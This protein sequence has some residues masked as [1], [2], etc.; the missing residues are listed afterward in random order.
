MKYYALLA[1]LI[2]VLCSSCGLLSPQQQGDALGA[3]DGMLRAGVITQEQWEALRA[4]ILGSGTAEFWTQ[5]GTTLGGAALAYFGV[6]IRRGPVTND[7]K[8]AEVV[9]KI[10]AKP[11]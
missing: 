11:A 9:A 2:V 5:L 10:A 6:Q 1:C 8:I 4:A 7:A 3:I